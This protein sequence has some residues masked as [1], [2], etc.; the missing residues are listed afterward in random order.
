MVVLTDVPRL[1]LWGSG[2]RLA[3][4]AWTVAFQAIALL[5]VLGGPPEAAG[6]GAR[7]L[8]YG[9]FG[10]SFAAWMAAI[11]RR[12][13]DMGRSG[14]FAALFAI[15]AIGLALL[16]W[17]L[18]ATARPVDP[19]RF[20]RA[21]RYVLGALALLLVAAALASRAFWAPH[22]LVTDS[23][24]PGLPRG[25]L[26]V[27]VAAGRGDLAAGEVV[28]YRLTDGDGLGR[29]HVARVLALPGQSFALEDGVPRIDGRLASQGPCDRPAA[30]LRETLPGGTAYDVAAPVLPPT[31]GSVTVPEGKLLVLHDGLSATTGT[32]IPA[33]TDGTGLVPRDAVTGQVAAL[34]WRVLP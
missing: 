30:C 6:T 33:R 23:M 26:F 34:P 11:I 14:W 20:A 13:H 3:L 28:T 1:G 29:L 27:S 24:A 18:F 5:V 2:G 31:L 17:A 21:P 7:I 12:L 16:V 19:S 9:L 32:R 10:L 8:L 25:T 22:R 15:P 4:L